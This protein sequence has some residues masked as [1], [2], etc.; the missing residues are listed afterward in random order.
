MY[1]RM[2]R[3]VLPPWDPYQP[4]S[5]AG[6]GN[7]WGPLPLKLQ[8]STHINKMQQHSQPTNDKNIRLFVQKRRP[9]GPEASPPEGAWEMVLGPQSRA[10]EVQG[11]G[12]L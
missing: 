1:L 9:R 12:T 7:R 4:P 3:H 2:A 11:S 6:E 5:P 8:E 10:S